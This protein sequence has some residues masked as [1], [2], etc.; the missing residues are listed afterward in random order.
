MRESDVK[1]VHLSNA[2]S[3]GMVWRLYLASSMFRAARD[4]NFWQFSILRSR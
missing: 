1:R 2:P 4:D 3:G